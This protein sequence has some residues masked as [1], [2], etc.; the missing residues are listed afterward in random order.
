MT[1]R[2]EGALMADNI[3][4]FRWEAEEQGMDGLGKSCMIL[5]GNEYANPPLACSRKI[6]EI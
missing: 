4:I 2:R 5:Y 1:D 3:Y 6:N